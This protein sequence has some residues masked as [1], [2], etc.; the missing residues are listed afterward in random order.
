MRKAAFDI[1]FGTNGTGKTTVMKKLLAI[2]SRNLILPANRLDKAWNEYPEI[3][4]QKILIEVTKGKEDDFEYFFKARGEEAM[5]L[6]RRFKERLS[7]E[8]QTFKG[9]K[10][11]FAP[12]REIFNVIIH[13]EK[14][15][16]NG[17]L[18][19]DDFKNHIPKNNLPANVQSLFGDRRHKMLDIFMAAHSPT[20]MPPKLLDFQPTI[21]L[22][23]T[24]SN[25]ERAENKYQE[26]IMKRLQDAQ[27]RVNKIAHPKTGINPYHFEIIECY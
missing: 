12:H 24:T 8:L 7:K 2:N 19:I 18:F 11:I 10:K 4:V 15:F 25:F 17:G 26:E 14:G 23:F 3:N 13:P 9:N 20:D 16:V 27:V 22:F 5:L 6:Q 1:L 21:Y